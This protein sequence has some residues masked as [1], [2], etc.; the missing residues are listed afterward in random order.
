MANTYGV[1]ET[2]KST[3]GFYFGDPCYVMSREDYL[4]LLE[5]MSGDDRMGKFTVNGHEMIVDNTAYGDGCYGG[6]NES[7]GVDAGMLGVIPLELVKQDPTNMGWV[8][9]ETGDVNM[10]TRKDGS[11]S[12]FV[13]DKQVEGV[14]TGDG[15]EDENDDW[16]DEDEDE[17]ED[18]EWG[19][20]ED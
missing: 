8:C 7:Y 15:D 2:I 10:S 20:D 5:Q 12:V 16:S 3:T 14:E 9:K 18:D 4:K 13:N 1:N 17:V 11:F 6:W 19:E